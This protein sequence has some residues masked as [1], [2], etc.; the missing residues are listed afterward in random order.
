MAKVVAAVTVTAA[1]GAVDV[2][3]HSSRATTKFAGKAAN[4]ENGRSRGLATGTRH[5]PPTDGLVRLSL[6]SEMYG[7]L[8][9]G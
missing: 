7:R 9:G 1:G 5:L 6:D 4:P 3:L 2:A 8:A